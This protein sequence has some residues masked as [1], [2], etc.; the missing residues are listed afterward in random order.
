MA[1]R[2]SLVSS[3]PLIERIPHKA[4][5]MIDQTLFHYQLE[6]SRTSATVYIG[7]DACSQHNIERIAR[8]IDALPRAMRVLRVD[9]HGVVSINLQT[10]MDL[11]A[12]LARWRTDRDA[13][14]RLVLRAALPREEWPT[15]AIQFERPPL[16][17]VT[18]S[19]KA[20]LVELMRHRDRTSEASR[21]RGAASGALLRLCETSTGA[22]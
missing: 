18:T 22:S 9:L 6:C 2:E 14:V 12:L 3:I 10:L 16:R 1:K 8:I 20:D 17:L 19:H 13:N 11:R 5:A 15:P 4:T 21:L 7:G